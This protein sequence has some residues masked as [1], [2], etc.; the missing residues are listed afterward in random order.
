MRRIRSAGT[1]R[2]PD[3][4][5]RGPSSIAGRRHRSR[6]CA[7]PGHRRDRAGARPTSQAGIDSPSDRQRC[8]LVASDGQDGQPLRHHAARRAKPQHSWGRMERT[9]GFETATLTLAKKGYGIRPG[10][11]LWSVERAVVRRFVRPVR[12]VRSR[13]VAIVN[14]LNTSTNR[15]DSSAAL[16]PSV[17]ARF[18][19][20]RPRSSWLSHAP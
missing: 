9:T 12:R 2:S 1:A 11:R 10:R 20:R 6:V 7:G 19:G 17:P 15:R 3:S 18:V 5:R 8:G 13:P 4:R 16:R 14:A